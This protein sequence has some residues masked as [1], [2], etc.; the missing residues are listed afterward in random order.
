LKIVHI[1]LP[2]NLFNF[3]KIIITSGNIIAS[4]AVS[5]YCGFMFPAQFVMLTS[6]M[7]KSRA[8]VAAIEITVVWNLSGVFCCIMGVI[9]TGGKPCAKPVKTKNQ[10]V[11]IFTS[12][13]IGNIPRVAIP[14]GMINLVDGFKFSVLL[15]SSVPMVE[16]T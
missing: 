15:A 12:A 3:V 10:T 6:G 13:I 2:S 11:I 5:V 7:Y 16:K 14:I 4:V 9:E 8:E 1:R